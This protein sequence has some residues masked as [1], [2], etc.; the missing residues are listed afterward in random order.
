MY[1]CMYIYIYIHI[2]TYIHIYVYT[3]I[4]M[5]TVRRQVLCMW[6]NTLDQELL[7]RTSGALRAQGLE[8]HGLELMVFS[9]R[10]HGYRGEGEA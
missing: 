5:S 4:H 3:Y 10:M 2:Y 9:M 1:V 6:F 8:S 7:I